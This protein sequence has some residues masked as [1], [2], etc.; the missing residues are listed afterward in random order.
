MLL[1]SEWG[2]GGEGRESAPRSY[3]T[4]SVRWEGALTLTQLYS[5][6]VE[7]EKVCSSLTLNSHSHP[8]LE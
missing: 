4:L 2:S 6:G 8:T 1:E 7:R 5:E 3:S